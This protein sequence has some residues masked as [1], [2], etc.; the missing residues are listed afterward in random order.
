M[1]YSYHIKGERGPIRKDYGLRYVS[2]REARTFAS[3]MMGR[4]NLD[5]VYVAILDRDNDDVLG[6]H[7]MHDGEFGWFS[8]RLDNAKS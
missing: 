5:V 1:R 2:L 3:V 6:V 7:E 4:D 8:Q